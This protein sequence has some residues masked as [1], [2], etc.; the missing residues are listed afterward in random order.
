MR[1]RKLT[2]EGII[3]AGKMNKKLYWIF[4]MLRKLRVE[5]LLLAFTVGATN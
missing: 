5:A 3:L 2:V 1:L 4:S